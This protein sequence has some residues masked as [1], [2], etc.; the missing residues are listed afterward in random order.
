MYLKA[1]KCEFLREK[2]EYL[3]MIMSQNS[4]EMDLIKVSGVRDRPVPT[5]M[6]EVQSFLGFVNFYRRFIHDFSK[7]GCPLFDLT[8]QDSPFKWTELHQSAFDELKLCVTSAP[9]LL[10]PDMTRHF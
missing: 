6:K 10:I 8:K 2:I 3:G 1:E 7:I 4:V 5:N 9:V